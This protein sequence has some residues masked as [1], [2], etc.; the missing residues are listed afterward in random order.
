MSRSSPGRVVAGPP[1]GGF[2]CLSRSR[3]AAWRSPS[4]AGGASAATARARL[5][6]SADRTTPDP[7]CP[8]LPC[9][10]VG[11]VTGFQISN[12]QTQPPVPESPTTARS[13]RGR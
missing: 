10:A 9:Q 3:R 8:E 7:S 5:W 13:R 4:S 1:A 11:S 12:G 2:G 6:C